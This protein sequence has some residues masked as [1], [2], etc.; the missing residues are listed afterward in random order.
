MK[1][2]IGSDHAGYELKKELI[3]YFSELGHVVEDKGPFE[4]NSDDDYPD[5][6]KQVAEAVVKDSESFGVVLGG[7]GQ[8]EA[9]CAN[10][11]P[12][13]RTALFYS[14]AIPQEAVDISGQKSVDPYEIIKLAR[15]HN[16]ANILSLGARFLS[17]D[18]MKF[19]I[20][21]FISTEFKGEE[22]HIRRI[23]KLG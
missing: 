10:R 6:I 4:Y 8:G 22:R 13:A 15:V 17:K 23:Q 7:S 14:E 21:L 5:F 20:E 18:Q 19:S 16:N 12:G 2:Y 3:N 9:M 11:V 1:I